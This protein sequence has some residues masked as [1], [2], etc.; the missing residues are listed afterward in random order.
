M[1]VVMG[2]VLSVL[3]VST[4]GLGCA[5]AKSA[6][7]V[8]AGPPVKDLYPL[9]V[10]HAWTYDVEL[11]GEKRQLNV[12]IVKQAEGFFVD[13]Q[14]AKLRTDST[15]VRDTQRYLLR[16]PLHEGRKWM[17][18]LSPSVTEHY[19]VTSVGRTC[20][21]PAGEF[22]ECVAV[23]SRTRANENG[24][25]VNRMTFATGV[26]LVESEVDL[27]SA[28]KRIPQSRLRLKSYRLAQGPTSE[29]KP[30]TT[31]SPQGRESVGGR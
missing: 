19:Q 10:G 6:Q 24:I 3:V 13:N 14:G 23:E 17:N 11:L 4:L 9:A 26:G 30:V 29:D 31:P 1:R 7:G 22:L 16:E 20:R 5:G 21:T 27:E 18:V 2:W 15:G 12:E 8:A 25:L 28:G